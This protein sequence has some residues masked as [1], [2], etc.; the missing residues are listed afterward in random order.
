MSDDLLNQAL[1]NYCNAVDKDD[2]DSETREELQII[3]GEQRDGL[4]NICRS[5]WSDDALE[6]NYDMIYCNDE[7]NGNTIWDDTV[8]TNTITHI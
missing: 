5:I 7:S 6:D 2:L 4:I 3:Y 1:G 8:D